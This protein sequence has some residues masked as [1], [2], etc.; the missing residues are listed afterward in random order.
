ML[1][2][3]SQLFG[4]ELGVDP[5]DAVLDFVIGAFEGFCHTFGGRAPQARDAR[6]AF[7]DFFDAEPAAIPVVG[8]AR[9]R[10]SRVTSC[11]R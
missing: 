1:D 11:I 3:F 2:W 6:P 8:A 7:K 10:N 4:V 9:S 5:F